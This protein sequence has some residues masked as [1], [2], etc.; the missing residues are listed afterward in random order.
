MTEI[1]VSDWER[2]VRWYAD[3]LGFPIKLR[4]A[5]GLFALLEREGGRGRIALKGGSVGEAPDRRAVRLVF[6]VGD[7]DGVI[8]TLNHARIT[9]E[10][11]DASPEGYAAIKLADPDGT[12]IRIFAWAR[13]KSESAG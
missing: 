10:G 12:P 3:V 8:A 4:D 13:P 5:A 7:L 1:V 2:S 11:P 6:E 9:F